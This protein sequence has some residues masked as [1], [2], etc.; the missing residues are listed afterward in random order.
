MKVAGK[1]TIE[2]V[3]TEDGKVGGRHKIEGEIPVD[4]LVTALETL[5]L[6]VMMNQMAQM[7]QQAMKEATKRIVLPQGPLPGV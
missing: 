2:F 1:L 4:A 3:M 5:K 6:Q 7:Q